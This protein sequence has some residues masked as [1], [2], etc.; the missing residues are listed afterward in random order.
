MLGLVPA[1]PF[2]MAA[3]IAI[4]ESGMSRNVAIEGGRSC[5]RADVGGAVGGGFYPIVRLWSAQSRTCA[6]RTFPEARLP[7]C[8]TLSKR[9]FHTIPSWSVDSHVPRTLGISSRVEGTQ[10]GQS[11]GSGIP[12]L[13]QAKRQPRRVAF[14]QGSSRAQFLMQRME[15]KSLPPP[16]SDPAHQEGPTVDEL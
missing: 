8:T 14:F 4:I 9:S 13:K 5:S 7:A 11:R 2:P 3:T 12:S 6:L 15:A 1:F 10:Q 16:P